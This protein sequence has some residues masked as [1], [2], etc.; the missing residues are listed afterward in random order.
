[1]K[2]RT[3]PGFDRDWKRLREEHKRIFRDA[4]PDFSKACDAHAADR[5]TVWPANL[6]VSQMTGTKSIWEMTWSFAGPG[7]R[8]TFEFVRD[9]DDL[10]CLWR[11][12]GDHSI[13]NR[14]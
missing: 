2:F 14:P 9:G 8:A 5:A 4:M 7:G 12:I 11:R 13:Y 3:T 10:L 1:L 6:R